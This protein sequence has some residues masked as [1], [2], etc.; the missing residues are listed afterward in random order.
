MKANIQKKKI[1]DRVSQVTC[2]Q[3][4]LMGGKAPLVK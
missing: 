4:E 2:R 1:A 3:D